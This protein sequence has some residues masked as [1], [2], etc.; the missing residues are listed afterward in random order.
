MGNMLRKED[1]M[2][3]KQAKNVNQFKNIMKN[4]MYLNHYLV[5]NEAFLRKFSDGVSKNFNERFQKILSKGAKILEFDIFSRYADCQLR[6]VPRKCQLGG[7][8]KWAFLASADMWMT[9][10]STLELNAEQNY[11]KS[12]NLACFPFLVSHCTR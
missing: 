3:K 6:G 9:P 5:S 2:R 11:F 7:V 12:L 4:L 8:P 10:Y 1:K